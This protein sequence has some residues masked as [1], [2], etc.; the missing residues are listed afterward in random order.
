MKALLLVACFPVLLSGCSG[1][2]EAMT[3]ADK[4]IANFHKLYNEVRIADIYAASHSKLKAAITE[5]EFVDFMNAV[6]RKLGKVTQTSS[7]GFNIEAFNLTTTVVLAQ[8]TTFEHGAGSE[9]FAF[10][11][12]GDK[13]VL[14]GYN[15]A[16][17]D[18]I[19]K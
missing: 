5:K 9:T 13:A 2:F 18:L 11:M 7:T 8:S 17:N 1:A 16:S 15:I 19:M 14:V 6:Q 10:E 12:S 3:A 4:G